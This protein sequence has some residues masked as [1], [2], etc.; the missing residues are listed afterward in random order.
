MTHSADD[1]ADDAA[2]PPV[3][4]DSRPSAS[5]A[6]G[7]SY[8]RTVILVAIALGIVALDILTKTLIVRSVAPGENV[9]ILGGLVYLT[10]IRNPGAAFNMATG[11]TWLLAIIALGV[12]VFIIRLAPKL[13]STPWAVC[14]GLILGGALG[15]LIDR[16]FRAPGFLQ[17]HVVDF[18]SL[19][20]PN[21]E[22]FPAFNAADSG[23][24][25]G[26]VLLVILALFG[27]D[28][29]GSHRGRRETADAADQATT[30]EAGDASEAGTTEEDT[31]EAD[32]T[33]ADTTEKHGAGGPTSHG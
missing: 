23:I 27:I 28:Y 30:P 10:Q 2:H 1:P 9:R 14:L 13:K 8:R 17:G 19:F 24:T 29:D 12:V 26:G 7:R 25:V 15:N 5:P 16:I 21:A 3:D 32:T 6:E 11:M 33:E 4:A 18:V 22:H 31:T 20:G